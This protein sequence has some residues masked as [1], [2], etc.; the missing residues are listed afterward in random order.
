MT[1]ISSIDPSLSI[2]DDRVPPLSM[3]MARGPNLA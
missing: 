2:M 1:L 3:R